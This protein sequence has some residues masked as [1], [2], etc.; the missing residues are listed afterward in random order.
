MTD[1]MANV[2]SFSQLE[3]TYKK[4]GKDIPIFSIMFGDASE[5]ELEEIAN[6]SNAKVFNGKKNLLEAF[7]EVRGY[8]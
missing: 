4:I 1:G 6:L 2:G 7:K 8:N 5:I 3:K